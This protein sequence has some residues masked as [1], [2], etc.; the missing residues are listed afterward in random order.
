ML[1]VLAAW[2]LMAAGGCG[3]GGE[4]ESSRAA[5]STDAT[6]T[7]TSPSTTADDSDPPTPSLRAPSCQPVDNCERATGEIA[8]VERVDPDGDGDAHFIL[9]SA[10]SI[11]APGISII[12]VRADL[13]PRPLP[14]PGDQLA[15]SGPVHEGSFGQRQ[16]Q[17][18]AI[19][20]RR[21]G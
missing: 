11:T 8:F 1:L 13:R 21:A 9:L 3:W 16:I 7:T 6:T 17:A 2:V 14:E 19:R 4:G 18:D 20:Y 15:A 12:D 5:A 10:E